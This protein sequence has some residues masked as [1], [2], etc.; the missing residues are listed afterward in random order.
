MM[1]KIFLILILLMIQTTAHA[2]DEVYHIESA[3]C[4][5][6]LLINGIEFLAKSYC[7]DFQFGDEV[8]FLDGNPDG[9]CSEANILNLRNN[10]VC[11]TWCQTPL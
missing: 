9:N 1:K 11:S 10:Q 2:N 3:S 6:T 4:A 5:E 8:V 7:D